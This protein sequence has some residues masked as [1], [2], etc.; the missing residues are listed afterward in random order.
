MS[1]AVRCARPRNMLEVAGLGIEQIVYRPDL[2][3][4][5]VLEE[6]ADGKRVSEKSRVQLEAGSGVT[7]YVGE[8]GSVSTLV[9]K[10]VGLHLQQAKS[11]CGSWGSTS[12]RSPSTRESTC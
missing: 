6:Y 8:S 1:P 2:A 7:L 12:A 5:Y 9:P 11:V 10:T 3:T 4:N